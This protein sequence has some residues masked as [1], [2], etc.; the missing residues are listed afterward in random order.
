MVERLK[1]EAMIAR[2]QRVGREISL[3]SEE[4]ENYESNIRD[5]TDL[6]QAGNNKNPLQF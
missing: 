3:S 1:I 4:E 5:E 2:R 6:N